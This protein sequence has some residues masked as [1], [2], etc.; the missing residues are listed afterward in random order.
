MAA[1]FGKLGDGS[2]RELNIFENCYA[3]A[4][5][6]FTLMTYGANRALKNFDVDSDEIHNGNKNFDSIFDLYEDETAAALAASLGLIAPVPDRISL[7]E[8][9]VSLYVADS[10]TLKATVLT[11]GGEVISVPVEWTTQDTEVIRLENGVVTAL[12]VGSATVKVTYGGIEATCTVTVTVPQVSRVELSATE[13]YLTVEGSRTLTAKAYLEDG[14]EVAAEFTWTSSADGI[15]TV[16]NG[17]V[18]GVGA[19]TA[20]ITVKTGEVTATCQVSVTDI[21]YADYAL[22][23]FVYEYNTDK[24]F[25]I[26]NFAVEDERFPAS[27]DLITAEIK[28]LDGN[29]ITLTGITL[30]DGVLTIPAA[31]F[32]IA[33]MPT[34]EVEMTLYFNGAPMK[35]TGAYLVYTI[36]TY[37]ELADMTAHLTATFDGHLKLGADIDFTGHPM[38]TGWK[39]RSKNFIGIFDGGYHTVSNVVYDTKAT[40]M[41]LLGNLK[42]PAVVKNLIMKNVE[43]NTYSGGI[44]YLNQ[45]GTIEN[46]Y[47]QGSINADGMA[48][49]S[50]KANFGCGLLVGRSYTAT[51]AIK[52]CIVEVTSHGVVGD[53]KDVTDAKLFGSAA[54]G[55][56]GSG[57]AQGK[58]TGCVAI[59]ADNFTLYQAGAAN[60]YSTFYNF[61]GATNANFATVDELLASDNETAKALA[62]SFGIVASNPDTDPEPAPEH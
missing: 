3:V 35:V 55:M 8:T 37:E 38:T 36:N 2:A 60:A 39:M 30:A 24:D 14:S 11:A 53:S 51:S 1:A 6:G 58:Y 49:G 23:D 16:A 50:N 5:N 57:V 10:V 9:Q 45:G 42:A 44:A 41:G 15:A 48:L 13:L 32:K 62:A 59:N 12:A 18:T 29:L 43:I 21:T 52:N 19:G 25:V 61:T 26:E 47:V 54:F 34:K 7:S 31:Q 33:Q 17:T 27:P 4:A 46:C 40:A 22:T 56:M 28:G 20:T